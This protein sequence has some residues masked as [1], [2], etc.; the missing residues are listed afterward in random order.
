MKSEL[1]L[2]LC[3]MTAEKKRV[4]MDAAVQKTKRPGVVLW[5]RKKRPGVVLQRPKGPGEVLQKRKRP[6]AVLQM[7][8]GPGLILWKARRPGAILQKVKRPGVFPQKAKGL[9]VALQ[10]YEKQAGSRLLYRPLYLQMLWNL[11]WASQQD[12]LLPCLLASRSGN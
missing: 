1:T 7:A 6:G 5:R 12:E 11:P 9:D 2:L 4:R 3:S 10:E 8:T